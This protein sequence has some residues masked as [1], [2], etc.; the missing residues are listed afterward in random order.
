MAHPDEETFQLTHTDVVAIR[1]APKQVKQVEMGQRMQ[2]LLQLLYFA[3]EVNF[4]A[5]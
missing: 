2:I 5:E 4:H 3:Q 1:Q